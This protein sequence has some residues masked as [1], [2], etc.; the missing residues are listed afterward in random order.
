MDP[1]AGR[2]REGIRMGETPR[3]H[4][5]ASRERSTEH[6]QLNA[7]TLTSGAQPHAQASDSLLDARMVDENV[8]GLWRTGAVL[9]VFFELI[10]AAEH[11][12]VSASTFDATLRLHL[13]NIAI[14][15][16]FFLSSFTPAMPRY[17]RQLALFVCIALLISTTAICA[18]STRVASLFVSTLVF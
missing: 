7:A 12:Y 10:Y 16:V 5:I 8:V 18:R 14:G 9:V 17:W 15:M 13:A 4:D 2:G 3:Q 1:C 6:A 11:H